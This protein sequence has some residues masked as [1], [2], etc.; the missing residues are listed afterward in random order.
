MHPKDVPD[1][2]A[3]LNQRETN[4]YAT[5]KVSF[6]PREREMPSFTVL[7]YIGTET[8]PNYLGPVPIAALIDQVMRSRGHSGCNADYVLQLAKVMREI[9]PDVQDEHLFS[10]ESK[11][12]KM[13][14]EKRNPSELSLELV[15]QDDDCMY[16]RMMEEMVL[17]KPAMTVRGE[18]EREDMA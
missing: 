7:V 1:V 15:C 11:L 10:L 17:Q 14:F 6:Y 16:K 5:H 13:M 9:A 18:Q 8:H 4:S 3:Y 12:K 2:M